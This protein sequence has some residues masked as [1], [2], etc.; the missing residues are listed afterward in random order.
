MGKPKSQRSSIQPSKVC[1]SAS[2][3]TMISFS[4]IISGTVETR[5]FPFLELLWRNALLSIS[6]QR[7]TIFSLL[8]TNVLSKFYESAPSAVMVV[9]GTMMLYFSGKRHY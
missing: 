7:R 8:K 5:F 6:G 9:V 3:E 4:V 2:E 1:V